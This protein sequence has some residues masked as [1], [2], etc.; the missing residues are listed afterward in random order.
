MVNDRGDD[1]TL[2]KLNE[3]IT[4]PKYLQPIAIA[5]SEITIFSYT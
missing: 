3:L 2:K 5:R 4:K 1:K